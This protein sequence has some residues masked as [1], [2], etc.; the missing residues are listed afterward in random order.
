M[1]LSLEPDLGS[2]ENRARLLA[3]SGGIYKLPNAPRISSLRA[4][5]KVRR[6]LHRLALHS[7]PGWE[8]TC[9]AYATHDRVQ[10]EVMKIRS[11]NIH[12]DTVK[13]LVPFLF[14]FSLPVLPAAVPNHMS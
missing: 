4:S 11:S 1:L 3:Q 10:V 6:R 9:R 7:T 13:A 5:A 14:V 12:T 2:S 8:G